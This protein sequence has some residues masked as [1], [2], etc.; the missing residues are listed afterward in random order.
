MFN[1]I[2]IPPFLVEKA[3]YSIDLTEDGIYTYSKLLHS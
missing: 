3:Y 1:G 2:T